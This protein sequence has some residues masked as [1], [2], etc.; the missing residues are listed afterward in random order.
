MKLLT[1]ILHTRDQQPLADLLRGLTSV[2]GYTLAHVDGFGDERETE[3]FLA[4]H[5]DIV[6]QIPR[7]RADLM[8]K[9]DDVESVLQS[10][11]GLAGDESGQ[12]VY[13]ITDVERGG[14]IQ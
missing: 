9:D 13:W 1:L 8:L 2:T 4:A 12:G 10:I 6:G 5:D 7:I 3:D 11:K 14:H